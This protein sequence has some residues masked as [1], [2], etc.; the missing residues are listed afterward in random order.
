[1]KRLI[2][3]SLV[4]SG[5]GALVALALVVAGIGDTFGVPSAQTASSLLAIFCPPWELFWA[6]IGEP[7]NVR[8]WTFLSA[9]VVVAN[10]L[11]YVP[12]GIAHAATAHLRSSIRYSVVVAA[13]LGSLGLGHVYF[14]P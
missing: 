2:R 3:S 13:T 6:G 5:L 8:L 10:A 11:L 1:M 12:A 9:A 7:H 14:I 4:A